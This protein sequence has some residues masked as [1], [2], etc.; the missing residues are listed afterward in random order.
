MSTAS[1]DGRTKS[2]L[3]IGISGQDGV[4]LS[5]LLLNKGYVVEGLS[6]NPARMNRDNMAFA[7]LD[8]LS[9][10]ELD[11]LNPAAVKDF[12][13]RARFDEVY[14]LA[15]QSSVGLSFQIPAETLQYNI[16]SVLNLLEAL[17]VNSPHTRYYQASSSEMFGNIH[18]SDLPVNETY[19]FQPA[20]PYGISKAT[21]HWLTVTYRDIYNLYCSCG[22][23]FNHESCLRGPYFVSKKII[24][25]AIAI[26]EN[27]S[28]EKLTLG[29]LDIIR[30]WGYAPEY[31]EAMWLM[32]QQEKAS[33]YLV[34]TGY[35]MSLKDFVRYAFEVL[36][37]DWQ[38]HVHVE[39]SLFRPKELKQ[40]YGDNRKSK[41]ELNWSHRLHGKALVEQ[42]IKDEYELI[43]FYDA[44]SSVRQETP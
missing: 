44:H 40:M 14:N 9:M 42:L 10:H 30:D 26:K 4:Y 5:R 34:C 22:V 38:Q 39:P 11:L 16:M 3:I 6:T 33:D 7:G 25:G 41:E 31:V 23:L 24:S 12:F 19:F 13:V 20:S 18:E 37:M 8:G 43:K 28:R 21:A 27:K 15:A 29:N 36:G 1:K 35:P 32:L 2:A 17:R